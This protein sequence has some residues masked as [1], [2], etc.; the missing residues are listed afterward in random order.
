MDII[1]AKLGANMAL[2]K[3]KDDGVEALALKSADG[4]QYEVTVDSNG[5][6]VVKKKIVIEGDATITFGDQSNYNRLFVGESSFYKVSDEVLTEEELMTATLSFNAENGESYVYGNVE[7]IS[8]FD[9]FG[10]IADGEQPYFLS[11]VFAELNGAT[12]AWP[13]NFMLLSCVAN[14]FEGG[15]GIYVRAYIELEQ[16]PSLDWTGGSITYSKVKA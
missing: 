16:S 12:L 3:L 8:N 10:S 14:D 6:L 1:T 5:Q 2:Q 4:K 7:K 11:A 13:N 9:S 15:K